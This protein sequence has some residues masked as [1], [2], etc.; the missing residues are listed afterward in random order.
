[1]PETKSYRPAIIQG[2]MGVA[3]SGWRLARSVASTG[4]LGVVSGTA[5]DLVL[6]R[7]LQR[8]DLDMRRAVEAFPDADVAARVL[9]AYFREDGLP[10]GR[11]YKAIPMFTVDPRRRSL[12][13]ATVGGFAEVWLAKEGHDGIVGINF[14]EKIQLPTPPTLYGAMLAGVDVV[15]VGAG[16]PREIPRLLDGLAEHRPIALPVHV[17]GGDK[18]DLEFDPHSVLPSPAAPLARPMFLA[19]IA[20]T[21]LA[22]SLA[23]KTPGVD[24]FVIEGPTAGGHNA[25]PRGT[26]VL[27]DGEPLYGP[28]DEVDLEKVGELGLPFW[29][30]GGQATPA[31][32][33]EAQGAGAAGIQVG[34]VFAFCEDSGMDATIRERILREVAAGRISVFTDPL[35][36]P[37]GFP[38][39][40]VGLEGTLSEDIVEQ[41][42]P[43]KCDLG[44]LRDVYQTPDG[45]LGY[46]CPAEPIDDYLSKGGDLAD[47]VGRKCI[48]NG[49]TA[50][51]G[52]GQRRPTLEEPPIVTAGDDLVALGRLLAPD[53]HTYSAADVVAYLLGEPMRDADEV[54]LDAA[55]AHADMPEVDVPE[56]DLPAG[57]RPAPVPSV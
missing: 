3:V 39:K 11:P 8:G 19:I 51:I 37:T 52:F 42:R 34:T 29:L 4:Q 17:V 41:A 46:R 30:A 16:I 23:R 22:I 56:A 48:C 32:L 33:R 28:R 2:G 47:T 54:G 57:E 50:T 1:M 44:Y 25:P 27:V 7:R 21:A 9:E 5:L 36:S 49:L 55:A 18:V 24:G 26:P 31:M 20:S 38:F 13:L 45:G 35:A 10:E 14:L 6:A 53:R 12:E 15:L 40:V 43:R